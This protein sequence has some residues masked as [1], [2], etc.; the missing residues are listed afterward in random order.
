MLV[1]SQTRNQC[2]SKDEAVHHYTTKTREHTK[3]LRIN[4]RVD[5]RISKAQNK[6]SVKSKNK[7]TK[8]TFG[9]KRVGVFQ[10]QQ[11]KMFVWNQKL[12]LNIN[13][14]SLLWSKVVS[15][16]CY[17]DG[18]QQLPLQGF[19]RLMVKCKSYRQIRNCLQKHYDDLFKTITQSIKK[20]SEMV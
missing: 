11:D 16:S 17:G 9:L 10:T 12:H 18:F 13:L 15:A 2:C 1:V 6:N 5:E 8:K 4:R 3:K 14:P 20:Y 7:T 19:Q